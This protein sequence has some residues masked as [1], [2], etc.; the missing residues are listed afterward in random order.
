[1][2]VYKWELRER[3]RFGKARAERLPREHMNN[4]DQ[5]RIHFG[6][7]PVAPAWRLSLLAA[8]ASAPFIATL[9]AAWQDT[10]R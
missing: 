3:Q 6:L 10:W 5:A 2:Q 9:A 7:A 1:M 4:S 8:S